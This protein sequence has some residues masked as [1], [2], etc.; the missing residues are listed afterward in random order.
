MVPVESYISMVTGRSSEVIQRKMTSHMSHLRCMLLT[1]NVYIFISCI[2]CPV[3]LS[4]DIIYTMF[5]CHLLSLQIIYASASCLVYQS[6]MWIISCHLVYL[7]NM[8][9]NYFIPT[10][11]RKTSY[12]YVMSSCLDTHHMLNNSIISC[13]VIHHIYETVSCYHAK[14]AIIYV[15]LCHDVLFG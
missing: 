2:R 7:D 12:S 13:L 4:S 14:L 5:K 1:C 8:Y 15:K 3:L 10:Y 9:V 6:I 11:F